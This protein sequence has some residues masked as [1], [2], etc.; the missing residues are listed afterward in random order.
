MGRHKYSRV[1]NIDEFSSAST[2]VRLVST[3]VATTHTGSIAAAAW[4]VP[5]GPAELAGPVA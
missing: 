2:N 4:A 3:D 1:A 5:A